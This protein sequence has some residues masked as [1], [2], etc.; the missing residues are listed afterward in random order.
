VSSQYGREGGGRER[1]AL[2]DSGQ[3]RMHLN[4]E[5]TVQGRDLG[6]F[7]D[8]STGGVYSRDMRRGNSREGGEGRAA[9]EG[10]YSRDMGRGNSREG[11]ETW[12]TG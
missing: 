4:K 10:V 12:A 9:S 6:I 5:S 3:K 2:N 8:T 7:K 1:G 11:G